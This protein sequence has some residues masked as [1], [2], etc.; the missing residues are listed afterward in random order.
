MWSLKMRPKPGFSSLANRSFSDVGLAEGWM[1]N[2]KLIVSFP[3]ILDRRDVLDLRDRCLRPC[4][5]RA[6]WFKIGPDP[7]AQLPC[8]KPSTGHI[9]RTCFCEARKSSMF[10]GMPLDNRRVNPFE[11]SVALRPPLAA[12]TSNGPD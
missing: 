12:G 10:A 8:D 2:F 6:R 4:L 5:F 9:A 11:G 1:S 7:P 3:V